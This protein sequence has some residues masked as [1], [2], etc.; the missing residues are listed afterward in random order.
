MRP[1]PFRRKFYASFTF[2]AIFGAIA[3]LTS[4]TL[5]NAQSHE[6]NTRWIAT[7]GT[8]LVPRQAVPQLQEEPT[9]R[10][11]L[12]W[13][14]IAVRNPNVHFKNQTL[15]QI[16][17]TSIGGNQVRVMLSNLF[18]TTPLEIGAATLS[19]HS[20]G[21][22]IDPTSVQVLTF[23][24]LETI[25]I[26]P[27]AVVLSD[28]VPLSI[29]PLTKLAIDLY[30]PG[31]TAREMSPVT[32]H[33][34]S[35]RT[36]YVSQPGNHA[37]QRVL[38]VEETTE[39]WFYLARMDVMNTQANG[40]IVT[41][42]DSITDGY[43]ASIDQYKTWPDQ[44]ANRIHEAGMHLG[45]VNVGIGGNRVLGDGAG[46]SALA[47]FDRDVL[48]QPGVTHV[49]VL[50]GI[51][52]IGALGAAP[53]PRVE[54]LIAGHRQLIARAHAHGIKILGATLTPYE[55][56]VIPGYWTA[57]G[58]AIRQALNMWIRT[59]GEYDAVIDFDV[60][61]R[62]PDKPLWFLPAYDVSDHLHPGDRGYT[63]MADAVDLNFFR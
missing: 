36:N 31:E 60:A 57:E 27:G 35:H 13:Q 16:L 61:T 26:L 9:S 37:G 32:T 44:L 18:G 34:R 17:R 1:R 22:Q 14:P 21:A 41:I 46:V 55:G 47:R 33:S 8:A 23:S 52:D 3:A 38:P 2:V 24:T 49:V 10:E 6:P 53:R 4:P 30:L 20:Q 7:W 54:D 50:E 19:L 48:L 43:G 25:R 42:G 12:G 63:A 11:D 62:D 39:S 15:R 56:T 58:D 40:V 29:P 45:V 28:P 51:N 5:L 59:S